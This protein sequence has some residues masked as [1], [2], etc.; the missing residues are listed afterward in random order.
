MIKDIFYGHY[1]H[2]GWKK[3][4]QNFR[5]IQEDGLG[6]IINFQKSKWNTPWDVTFYINY[7]LYIEAGDTIEN[8]TFPEYICQVVNRT[9]GFKG[10]YRLLSEE[11]IPEV[12][13]KVL[14]DLETAAEF[15]NAIPTKAEFVRILLNG[16][17]A[18]YSQTK[19]LMSYPICR[20]LADMGYR[21][22]VYDIIKDRE[23]KY[24]ESLKEELK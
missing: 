4:G 16:D 7:G 6:K 9:E 10:E 15:F 13:R 8:T 2:D 11:D 12:K 23:G 19:F 22:E 17:I 3:Q 20:L 24:F 21:K 14:E 1:R 5:Y 18:K